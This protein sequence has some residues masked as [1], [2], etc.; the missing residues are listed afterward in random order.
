MG[1]SR[2]GTLMAPPTLGY[3]DLR[4]RGQAIRNLLVHKGIEFNDKRYKF[5]PAPGFGREDWLKEKF[6]LGLRFPN[7][8]YYID[9][10]VKIVQSKAILRYLARKYDL[11]AR[12]EAEH[13]LL[14]MLAAQ[15]HDL[16]WGLVVLTFNPNFDQE[17]RKY[18]EQM[19]EKLRPW[20]EELE[21]KQW[22]LGARMSYADFILY[23]ALDWNHEFKPDVFQKF[24]NLTGFMKRFEELPNI[25]KYFTSSKYNKWPITAPNSKWGFKKE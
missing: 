22:V 2:T 23:E 15:A 11:D 16:A 20:N 9:G 24:P 18:E 8:P 7:L 25:H 4:G 19:E 17:R 10:D 3:W 6:T 1:T 13:Q 12:N 5:G 21:G 14:D